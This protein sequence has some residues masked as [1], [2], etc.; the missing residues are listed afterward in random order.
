MKSP[1][2]VSTHSAFDALI[3]ARWDQPVTCE[4][5]TQAG[6]SCRRPA[7]WRINLHG[8]EQAIA[9]GQHK[10]AW[11][12]SVLLNFGTSIPRC[13]HCRQKFATPADAFS[14]TPL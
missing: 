3:A 1:E 4:I 14:V 6:D 13:A 8:C 2:D 5:P 11:R 10:E 9:C 12:R 7:H